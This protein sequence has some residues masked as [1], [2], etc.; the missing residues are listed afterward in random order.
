[1]SPS[2]RTPRFQ[3]SPARAAF[4]ARGMS[5]IEIIIVVVLIG[6]IT[7]VVGQR[8]FGSRDQAN[9][10]LAETQLQT[11]A[12]KVDQFEMDVGR[13]PNSL[14]EMTTNPG[15]SRWLGPYIREEDA[16]DP[17]NTPIQLEVPGNNGR[18]ALISLGA[19]RQPG[20]DSVNQDIRF[21]P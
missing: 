4:R 15:E 11:V 13:L 19:D 18:Y 21:E 6:T 7:L 8:V 10:R 14:D 5:L 2:A 1:M 12:A 3:S 17:W 20:G 9:F 16:T